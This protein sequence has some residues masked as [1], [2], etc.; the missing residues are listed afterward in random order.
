M[1]NREKQNSMA[2]HRRLAVGFGAVNLV[3]ILITL[4]SVTVMARLYAAGSVSAGFLTVFSGGVA[5]L[6]VLSIVLSVIAC[7]RLDSSMTRP[8]KILNGI[9]TQL[10]QGDTSANVKVLTND[11]VGRLMQ[12]FKTMVESTRRQAQAAE[13]IAKGDLTAQVALNSDKDVLGMALNHIAENNS[14]MLSRIRAASGRFQRQ[15]GALRRV[16]ADRPVPFRSWRR[17]WSR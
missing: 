13:T 15:E 11:E 7:R 10:S 16:P 4:L 9:A 17:R 6:T 2:L 12:A 5:A 3:T 14:R 8:M 1:E